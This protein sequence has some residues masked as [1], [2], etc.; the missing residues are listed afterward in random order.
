MLKRDQVVNMLNNGM[1]RSDIAKQ[2]GIS[3][4]TVSAHIQH[5]KKNGKSLKKKEK[6]FKIEAVEPVVEKPVER[7]AARKDSEEVIRLK[8]KLAIATH[9]IKSLARFEQM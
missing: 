1:C 7:T 5:A 8:K 9:I 6:V 2:L 4:S 3:Q